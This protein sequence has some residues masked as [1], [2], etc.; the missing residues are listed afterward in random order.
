MEQHNI[1]QL[2]LGGKPPRIDKRTIKMTT[3]LRPELLP[4]LPDAYDLDAVLGVKDSFVFA[5]DK[6]GDCVIAGRG[7]WTLRAES[8]EQKQQIAITDKEVTDEYFKE[9]G[10]ADSGLVML[11]SLNKWRQDGWDIGGKTYTIDAFASIDC[12][13]HDEWKYCIYL[14]SGVYLALALPITAQ[15]QFSQGQPWDI[16]NPGSPESA[17]AS[18]G[19]H[20]VY[21]PT[22]IAGENPPPPPPAP[23]CIL[24]TVTAIPRLIRSKIHLAKVAAYNVIGPVLVTWG[25]KQQASW[26]WCDTYCP[27]AYGIVDSADSWLGDSSPIDAKKLKELLSEITS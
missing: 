15:S 8:L 4:P 1:S 24:G 12:K 7:H 22:W 2:K 10:G 9:S 6:L 26:N 11:D 21:S 25:V 3:L 17:P 27:E 14:L 20:C 13:N 18:W 23:G 19:Y 5:N 16:V